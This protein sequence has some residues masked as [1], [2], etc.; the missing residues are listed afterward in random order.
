[1]PSHLFYS[2]PVTLLNVSYFCLA[3]KYQSIRCFLLWYTTSQ[4]ESIAGPKSKKLF[5]VSKL[6]KEITSFPS[7]KVKVSMKSTFQQ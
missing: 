5:A 6:E 2:S 1:M 4:C 3:K 7:V